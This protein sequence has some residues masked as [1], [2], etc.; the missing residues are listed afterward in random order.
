MAISLRSTR[1][2]S[3]IAWAF[4]F[5]LGGVP[6]HAAE[7]LATFT[8]TERL[9][10]D[11]PRTLVTYRLIA[12]DAKA[13][14]L[15]T[16]APVRLAAP[17]RADNAK[18]VDGDG[19]EVPFQFS[20]VVTAP[21]GT[22]ASAWI[23][24]CTDLKRDKTYQFS[25]VTGSPKVVSAVRAA[26]ERDAV[27]LGN[28]LTSIRLPVSEAYAQPVLM[29]KT[30]AETSNAV[31]PILG[32]KLH[33][34]T[35]TAP[36]S[37][38]A[39][40][41]AAAPKITGRKTEILATGPLFA[42]ARVNYTFDNRG[43]YALTARVLADDPAIRIDEQCDL[44]T[45]RKARDWQVTIPL[46]DLAG[47]F[48]PTAAWWTTPGGRL[49]KKDEAFEKAATAAGFAAMTDPRYGDRRLFASMT[50]PSVETRQTLMPLAAWYPY[51][52]V[53]YYAALTD[54]RLLTVNDAPA[55]RETIPFVAVMP[56]HAGTWRGMPD[57]FNGELV[58]L[59]NGRVDV[60]WPLTVSPHP[61]SLLH[62]G[63][64]D[65]ALPYTLVRRQWALIA[66]PMQYHDELHRFR[67]YD[68]YITLDD[69]K[70]WVLDWPAAPEITYPRVAVTKARVDAIGPNLDNH[71]M[72]AELKQLLYFNDDPK[73]AATLL[74]AQA[75]DNGWNGVR[76]HALHC[77][78]RTAT[79]ERDTIWVAG[80]RD[81]QMA[82]WAPAVDEL[83]SSQHL[84]PD[85]RRKLRAWVAAACY[86]LAD[87]D[88]NPRGSMVHLGNP[89]M[90]MNRFFAL[91]FAAALIPDHPEAK[92]WLETSREYVRYI[93]SRSTAPEGGWSELLTYYMA[94]ASHTLQAAMVLDNQGMLDDETA[95]MAARAGMYPLALVAPR[96]PRFNARTMPAWGH[97]GYWMVPT[98]W[99][100]VATFT[101]QRDPQT[102][103]AMVWAWDQLGR[104]QQDHHDAGF[105]PRTVVNADLLADVRSVPERYLSSRWLPGFGAT[106]R[107]HI[108]D[109]NE[110]FL[111]YRQGYMVSHC[112]A[113]QGD[114]TLYAK[115]APLIS[116]SLFQYAIYNQSPF[117]KLYE[118]F[119]WHNRLRFGA[120]N[121]NGGWPGGGLI[122]QVHRFSTSNSV[123]YLRGLGDYAPQRWSR[124]IMF[125]KGKTASSPNYFLMQDA[126]RPL[127]G[128]KPEPKWWILRTDGPT[129]RIATRDTG[130]TYT[131]PWGPRLD[132]SFITPGKVAITSREATQKGPLYNRFGQ[133]WQAAGNPIDRNNAEQTMTVN[134][135][136]PIAAEQNVLTALYPLAIEEQPPQ[137]KSLAEGVTQI[138]TSEGTDI[139]FLA[140]EPFEYKSADITFRGRA[141]AVRLYRDEVHLIIAEGPGE[142]SYQG[143]TLK[144][145]VPSTHIL[146]R[147]KLLK[148]TIVE[149]APKPTI[150]I[151]M[152][153]QAKAEET[154]DGVTRWRFDGGF[155]W[156]FDAAAPIKFERDGAVFFGR[157]GAIVVD[158]KNGL[159]HFTLIDGERLGYKDASAF[160]AEGPYT[161]TYHRDRV[162][163]R[164]EGL[165]RFV[166]L[167]RPVGLDHLPVLLLNGQRFA[168][169]TSTDLRR[170][171]I[172]DT[173]DPYNAD[174]RGG[175]LIVPLPPGQ[176]SIELRE[177]PQPPIFRKWQAWP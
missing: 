84:S 59:P 87:P 50:L 166:Y 81:S 38:R 12:P 130:F 90:P 125:L 106:M 46:T 73:R 127:E 75:S 103:A 167:T 124:Q 144:S 147:T 80:F 27:V 67:R 133:L 161:L 47:K 148:Q 43:T 72:A 177:L 94:G 146:P 108:G 64:H 101:R 65:P 171:D 77:L 116:L 150:T 158:E 126:T 29:D 118:E 174:G 97:E 21:D 51:H 2:I 3:L 23:S 91:P 119:G 44:H 153:P 156:T 22:I 142:V 175:I 137:H 6:A 121:N 138:V 170:R 45:V 11:W 165:A 132:V 115:G 79:A 19:N 60:A 157:K 141:G 5:A 88:F 110:V 52:A 102:A 100:P 25:L 95:S 68:G 143:T 32:A 13:P 163:G 33:D 111:A 74:K 168:P 169:G 122:S 129:T 160:G 140:A 123:D 36:A 71:P 139:A 172:A 58:A 4:A 98:Q 39:D 176:Q 120:Q 152:P 135:V 105:S 66:G 151:D 117:Q 82:A 61:N 18:L 17:L 15:T 40:D 53:A 104:T 78:A 89:N 99:L 9:G 83:L 107:A 113:N 24:F 30:G 134:A 26:S 62:M 154:E 131:T 86:G 70:D 85:D 54:A 145:E 16:A 96:D 10:V 155:A 173:G 37:F 56:M 149:A 49:F 35:W 34:G 162:V 159:T 92:T 63:E 57:S 93:L 128:G 28:R 109:P 20:R 31:G 114:F 41:P 14:A 69:Y 112:D 136:G 164:A 42:E 1:R 76:G 55:A 48:Q 7:P 8:A